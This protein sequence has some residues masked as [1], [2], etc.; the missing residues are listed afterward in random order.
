MKYLSG[1]NPAEVLFGIH[2][3]WQ[4]TKAVMWSVVVKVIHPFVGL[5]PKLL[6][7]LEHMSIEYPLPVRTVKTFNERILGWFS[8]LDVGKVYSM[9]LAPLLCDLSYKL[10]AIIYPYP[11]WL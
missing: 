6:K 9:G 5:L 8:R 11:L 3:R 2:N 7:R 10:R 4:P 1:V